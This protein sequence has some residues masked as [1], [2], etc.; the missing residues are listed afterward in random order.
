MFVVVVYPVLVIEYVDD[1][2]TEPVTV[3]VGTNETL[4]NVEDEIRGDIVGDAVLEF[5]AEG[6]TKNI[7]RSECLLILGVNE[8]VTLPVIE[9]AAD[10]DGACEVNA[11][12]LCAIG[13]SDVRRDSEGDCVEEL[14]GEGVCTPDTDA[15]SVCVC[16]CVLM[17]DRV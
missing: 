9:E 2:D 15:N 6:V 4:W 10:C 12:G 17:A 5:I 3:G 14:L 11:D 13:V 8:N 7:P 16:I 1:D